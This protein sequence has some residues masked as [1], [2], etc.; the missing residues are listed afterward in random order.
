MENLLINYRGK[1][2]RAHQWTSFSPDKRGEQLIKDYNEQL[3][4]DIEDLKSK[5][6]ETEIIDGYVSRYKNLFGSWLGAKSRCISSMITG[7]SNFPIR[8]AEKANR[9][10]DNHFTLWQ[11]WRKRAKKAIVR[12]AQPK[13]TFM[14]GIEKYK[15]ELKSMQKNHELMKQG[16]IRIKKALK[17]GEDLTE[18]LTNTFGIMPHMIGW[19]LKFGFGL[20]NNNAN[21]KR[22]EERIKVLTSKEIERQ[23][24][25]ERSYSFD[26]GEVVV[27]YEIDRIQIKHNTKP[28]P[29]KI[30]ELKRNGFKW[31]PSQSAWQRQLTGNAI[32]AT[33]RLFKSQILIKQ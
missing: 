21:M 16:N 4:E 6:I 24:E 14:S 25:P 8:T 11:E 23:Q 22:V 7:P 26:G 19:T 20:A 12:K 2:I 28:D 27:N 15:E 18:Y 9:S 32:C 31:A 5:E 17:T 1:A 29:D 33:K 3:C 30:Q 13:P 10:E